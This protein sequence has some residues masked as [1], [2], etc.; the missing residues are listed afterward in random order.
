L[1]NDALLHFHGLRL[2][3][4]DF[5]VMP[6]HVHA[7]LTPYP[8]FEL[9]NILHSIKSYKA[10]QIQALRGT[11]GRLWMNESH[12]HIV[13]DGEELIRIQEYIRANPTKAGLR[14]DESVLYSARYA[15]Q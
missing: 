13:R 15:L 14:S 11:S 6:N 4:G 3:T 1:V 12:D 7:L 8:D 9:E 2:D 5:V 10:N